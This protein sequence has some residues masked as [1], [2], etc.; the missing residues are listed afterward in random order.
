MYCTN[1]G[2]KLENDARFCPECGNPVHNDESSDETLVAMAA[3]AS[4][5]ATAP[6]LA[7]QGAA[8]VTLGFSPRINDPA[9]KKYIKTPTAMLPSFPLPLP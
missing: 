3:A 9:F 6:P 7:L 1:C 8:N 4:V 5:S 2:E